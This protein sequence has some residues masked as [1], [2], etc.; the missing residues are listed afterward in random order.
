MPVTAADLLKL[1]DQPEARPAEPVMKSGV[2]QASLRATPDDTAS[3]LANTLAEATPGPAGLKGFVRGAAER[4]AEP[5]GRLA[6]AAGYFSAT[7]ELPPEQSPLGLA[8]DA[9][10]AGYAIHPETRLLAAGGAAIQGVGEQL[11]LTQ[12]SAR[13]LSIAAEAGVGVRGFLRAGKAAA[14]EGETLLERGGELR[15]PVTPTGAPQLTMPERVGAD[16]AGTARRQLLTNKRTLSSAIDSIEGQIRGAMPSIGPDNP[17]YQRLSDAL[18]QTTARQIKFPGDISTKLQEIQANI[19]AQQPVSTDDVMNL[20]TRLRQLTTFKD[21]SDPDMALAAKNAGAVRKTITDAVESG[22]PDEQLA[23]RWVEART[24]YNT[25]YATPW[26]NLRSIVKQDVTPQQA[27]NRV[28][29]PNDMATFRSLTQVVGD[30]PAIRGKLQMG[31]LESLADATTGFQEAEKAHNAFNTMRP[32]LAASGLFDHK[33]LEALDLFMRRRELPNLIEKVGTVLD[34]PLTLKKGGVGTAL[35]FFALHNP[36]L[37]VSAMVGAGALPQLRRLAVLPAGS[38]AAR[39]LATVA[40]AKTGQF[41]QA[42]RKSQDPTPDDELG[43][44]NE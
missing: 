20:R 39:R 40:L 33:E 21:S 34:E 13:M 37:A 23:A 1:A 36:V 25:Q 44:D 28:F 19:A 27:F 3:S 5:V 29:N 16:L 43:I 42:L 22:I 35:G 12:N 14:G 24:A 41:A 32:A 31:F 8:S 9:L 17:G 10:Q 11:G 18:E 2:G 30:S 26:R 6:G 7:G 38:P 15:Q 4:V